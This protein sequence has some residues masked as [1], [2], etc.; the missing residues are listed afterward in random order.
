[1]CVIEIYN[2]YAWLIPL[3]DI[4]AVTNANLFQK[5]LDDSKRKPN[6]IWV[7]KG[8]EFYYRSM[9][10]WLEKNDIEMYSTHNKGKSVVAERLIR[11]LQKRIYKHITAASKIY[12]LID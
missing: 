4:K 2:K 3:K 5:V 8:S 7:D 1:M 11:D 12:T 10:S 9:K 6:K